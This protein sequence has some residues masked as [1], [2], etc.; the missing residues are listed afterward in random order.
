MEDDVMKRVSR[1]RD[2][3]R[4]GRG[5]AFAVLVCVTVVMMA[6]ASAPS[7][8]YPLYQERWG[9][10]VTMLTVIFAVYV[11]GLLGALLTVGSLSDHLGRRPVLVAAMLMAA[12]STAIFWTADGVVSLM[13]A[14]VVQGIATGTAT[15]GLAAALVELSPERRPHLGPTMTVVGTSFGMATG[16]G[17][18]G[19]LV[20]STSR[21]D[22]Y[23]FPVLTL[24]FIVLAAVILTIPETRA[25]RAV[26]PASLRPTVR[27]PRE[28]R[29]EFFASVPA[30]VAGWSVTGLFLA[31]TPSLVSNVLQVRSGA[32][33]GI[34]IAALFLA[35]SVGGSWSVRHTARLATRLGAV[36]L[37]LGASGL[38]VAIAVAS[39]AIY[40]GGSVV[41]GLGVGL[42]F[43][44]SLRAISAVTPAKS[45]SEVFSA[46]YV[47]SYAALSLPALAAGLAAPS[48]GLE[49]TGY[50]YVGFVGALSLGA[51]LHA[52]RS[53]THGPGGDPMRTRWENGP[54]SE[55]IRC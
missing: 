44:G 11:V 52:G 10:S 28:A 41:A 29:P 5:A 42:T 34:S 35:N 17:V 37:T 26:G 36:L 45:R 21:P 1:P 3:R 14:R 30:L 23:V 39:P 4:L 25:P 47:I 38:A 51:A 54:H 27:V 20:Q 50:L 18:V 2:G 40:V 43:N 12:A 6:T 24:T 15:G 33:G 13:I 19:L 22:A 9:L 16:A 49:T 53:R 55:R 8:I 48:W 7:P 31:L 46:V 32:A